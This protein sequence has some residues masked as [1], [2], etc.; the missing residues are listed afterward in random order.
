MDFSQ[1]NTHLHP[2]EIGASPMVSLPVSVFGGMQVSASDRLTVSLS[3]CLNVSMSPQV[4]SLGSQV[5]P[6]SRTARW[7]AAGGMGTGARP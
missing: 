1:P 4:S 5:P 2:A 7:H 6:P 3:R